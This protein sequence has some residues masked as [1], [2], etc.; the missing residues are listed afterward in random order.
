MKEQYQK[1]VL[2]IHVPKELLEKTKQAM[3]EEEERISG[4][5]KAGKVIPFGKI[6]MAAPTIATRVSY[7]KLRMEK[8]RHRNMAR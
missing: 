4:K 6:S 7:L 5:K 1:E 8:M 2:Q 3:K